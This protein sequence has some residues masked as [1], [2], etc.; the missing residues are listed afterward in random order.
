VNEKSALWIIGTIVF[1]VASWAMKGIVN[2]MQVNIKANHKE[3]EELK[4][5]CERLRGQQKLLEVNVFK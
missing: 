1:I 2:E 4:L 3:I 5:N